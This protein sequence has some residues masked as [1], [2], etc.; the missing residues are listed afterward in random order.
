MQSEFDSTDEAPAAARP[1]ASRSETGGVKTR[2]RVIEHGEVFT[3]AWVVSD[4][5]DLLPT[6][7]A[8]NVWATPAD[9]AQKTFLDPTCGEGAFLVEVLERKLRRVNRHYAK[10]Q[11]AWEWH[12]ALAVSSIY[13]IELL[14]DNSER[15]VTNLYEVFLTHY[16]KRFRSSRN[17]GAL[18]AAK[19]IISRNIMQ[20]DALTL[21]QRDGAPILLSEFQPLIAGDGTRMLRRRDFD[22]QQMAQAQ[23]EPTL[24]SSVQEEPGLVV[25]YEPV[26][27]ECIRNARP[28]HEELCR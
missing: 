16:L 2:Q 3:P 24:F 28:A 22:F 10:S 9:A 19:F 21:T 6:R 1:D 26:F 11:E 27:W 13:G 17:A 15:C 4:M 8:R 25:E 18:D 7:G 5:L 23:S 12:A 20:G 14:E